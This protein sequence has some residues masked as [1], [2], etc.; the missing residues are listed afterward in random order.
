MTIIHR[1]TTNY[2]QNPKLWNRLLLLSWLTLNL[3]QS[4]LMEL[5][6]DEAYYFV[7]AE[8]LDFGYYDHPPAV[9]LLIKAGYLLFQN[10]LG[11][12]L[13]TALLSPL[14][15]W[16][17]FQLTNRKQFPLFFLMMT[18]VTIFHA[19]SFITV[20]DVP[21]LL[22][23][24]LL[25]VCYQR[26]LEHDSPLN[27]LLLSVTI[28]LLLYSK[29]HGILIL[30]F[31][32]LSNLALMRKRSFYVVVAV[33]IMA[34]LP[35]IIWQAVNHWPSYQ[36]HILAKSQDPYQ[37]MDTLLFTLGQLFIA[38]PFAGFLLFY[39]AWKYKQQSPA[40]KAMKYTLI[41]FMTFFLLS[42][43]NAR[44]EPNW[45]VAAFVPMVVLA[46]RYFTE[47]G[48]LRKW[49][50][51]LFA[52]SA[53]VLVLFRINLMTNAL[54]VAGSKLLPEFYGW[55]DWSES[56]RREAKGAP[57]AFSNSYQKASKY[58][59]YTGEPA[60]SLNNISYRRNQ[61]DL[62]DIADELQGKTVLYLPNWDLQHPGIFFFSTVKG[63]QNGVFIP[64]FRSYGHLFFTTGQPNYKLKAGQS[65]TVDFVLDN[66]FHRPATFGH[67]A[68]IPDLL[69]YTLFNEEEY[70]RTVIIR[71]LKGTIVKDTL[72]EKFTLMAPEKPGVYYL[73]LSVQ[74]GWLPAGMNSRLVRMVVE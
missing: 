69:T 51:I 8:H 26:Y 34:Y 50:V 19:Y 63:Q 16:T 28:A 29:Y 20:P 14:F 65:A 39:A 38:G 31:I 73:I 71:S 66:P 17:A 5:A 25:F 22:F 55:K 68:N 56:I 23:T 33:A 2:Q 15:I 40:E 24:A 72:H 45:T 58:H 6:N 27:V 42:T 3:F 37:P 47:P 11:V 64:D 21:L 32:L 61:Y 74:S 62:W 46:H 70:D 60:I 43:I 52:I 57:V 48:R 53:V 35:H 30:F 9:A 44:V 10:E 7:Y 4:G 49:M 36:Y 59:F 13:F 67:N 18:S 41:G 54:P 12:R 1:I